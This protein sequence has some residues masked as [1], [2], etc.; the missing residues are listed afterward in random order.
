MLLG[1]RGFVRHLITNS[2]IDT[3]AI[4]CTRQTHRITRVFLCVA[5]SSSDISQHDELRSTGRTA[6]CRRSRV[7][8]DEGRAADLVP[9]HGF[10]LPACNLHLLLQGAR[11]YKCLFP[12]CWQLT[13]LLLQGSVSLAL[14]VWDAATRNVS[15]QWLYHSCLLLWPCCQ[16]VLVL[17]WQ[18]TA[19]S[20]GVGAVGS[21]VYLRMLN[22]SIDSVGGFT[23]GAA[24]G[25][26]RLLVPVILTAAFNR[27]E[28][29]QF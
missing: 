21:L 23:V 16:L 22:R 25:Q 9:R 15:R 18:E 13:H 29:L 7:S 6:G 19:A 1:S 12:A 2:Q 26:P 14:L 5:G 17:L 24:M 10:G 28:P 4:D 27:Y 11:S 8:A 20:Y 3:R